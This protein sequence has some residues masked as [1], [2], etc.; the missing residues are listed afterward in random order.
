MI[1]PTYNRLG[2]V[3][4][5]FKPTNG[6][7]NRLEIITQVGLLVDFASISLTNYLKNQ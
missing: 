5:V 3:I 2:T 4:I 7:P 1:I 6:Y